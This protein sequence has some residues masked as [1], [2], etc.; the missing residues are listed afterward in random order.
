MEQRK[1]RGQRCGMQFL[2]GGEE[3]TL[4]VLVDSN[5]YLN[6]MLDQYKN[7]LLSGKTGIS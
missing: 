5:S 6:E 2:R 4:A 1:A 3:R 7:I